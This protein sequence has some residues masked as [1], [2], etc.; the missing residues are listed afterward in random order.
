MNK[1]IKKKNFKKVVSEIVNTCNNIDIAHKG[2][3]IIFSISPRSI[4]VNGGLAHQ[5]IKTIMNYCRESD[6]KAVAIS[7]F[8][9]LDVNVQE[10]DA[11]IEKLEQVI[12]ELKEK[13]DQLNK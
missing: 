11:A 13:R 1:R 12:T 8:K 7:N 6:I 3:V 9:G 2:D 4:V 10:Y 5:R